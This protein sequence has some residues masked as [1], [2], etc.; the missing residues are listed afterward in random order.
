VFQRT[1]NYTIP[2]HNA[3]LDPDYVR[4]VKAGYRDMRARARTKPAGI[5]FD[6]NVASAIETPEAER[7]RVYEK[8]WAYG[9]LGFIA[10]FSD[11]LLND[12][13]NKSAADFVRAKIREIV[14]D[15]AT[16]EILSPKNIIGCKRLCVDTGYWE[17][18]NRPNVTLVD[19]GDEPVERITSSG[20]RAKGKSYDFDC[21]VL[22]TGFDAMTGAL[23]RVD[24]R[25]RGGVTLQNAW[26]EG[27]K[28][29]LGLTVVGFPNLFTITGPGSPSVLTNM[30]PSI[31][32]HVEWI[33]DCLEAMRANGQTVIEA[34]GPAQEAWVGEVGKSASIT[35]RATC[36]SWYVGAN[37][38]G[39]PRV[40][41]PY[42]G[43]FPAYVAACE[44]VVAGGYKGFA[45][46]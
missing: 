34:T 13:S 4:R 6:I 17:T 44:E 46:A 21:L 26:R 15:P 42:I 3:P 24:V 2:A 18:F 7:R 1:A 39:K 32:Q 30:L 27:P 8:R 36:S 11:L 28:T 31:E 10:S 37:I 22:A 16:A 9:G 19:I 29:Y 14:K 5:D 38:P 25:G 12:D 43:G 45:L 20:V 40:F 35:L 33:A 41:M 23:L